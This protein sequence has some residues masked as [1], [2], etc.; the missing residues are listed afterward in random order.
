[1]TAWMT[2]VLFIHLRGVKDRRVQIRGR[3]RHKKIEVIKSIVRDRTRVDKQYF[4]VEVFYEGKWM[5]AAANHR[6]KSW[7]MLTTPG[8]MLAR[9]R[10]KTAPAGH[11]AR[12]PRM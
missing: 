11:H 6:M 5:W 1:M 7:E 9:V 8:T 12:R 10:P 2:I 3:L 4:F